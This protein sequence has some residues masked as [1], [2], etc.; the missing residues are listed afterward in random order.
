MS[1]IRV[2]KS[3]RDAGRYR[4]CD[5]PHTCLRVV[6]TRH[7][8]LRSSFMLRVFGVESSPSIAKTRDFLPFTAKFK[9]LS[10]V[11]VFSGDFWRV[12]HGRRRRH[13][14][15]HRRSQRPISQIIV[16]TREGAK[17]HAVSTVPASTGFWSRKQ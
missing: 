9:P 3:A 10:L 2:A 15:R 16:V 6:V 7:Y 14:R 1:Y 8:N 13:R 12:R 5:K 11:L 4:S 17:V